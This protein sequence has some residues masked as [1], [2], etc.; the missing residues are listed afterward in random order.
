M[1]LSRHF[2]NCPYEKPTKEYSIQNGQ[3]VCGKC[4]KA[5]KYQSNIKRHLQICKNKV[6]KS[7]YKCPLCPRTERFKCRLEKH[8][9]QHASQASIKNLSK[10]PWKIDHFQNHEIVCKGNNEGNVND[11]QFTPSFVFPDNSV[12]EFPEIALTGSLSAPSSLPLEVENVPND[13]DKLLII[14]K[15]VDVSGCVAS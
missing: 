15:R 5:I 2:K 10:L 14:F 4:S 7:L 8:V 3:Y 12:I 9:K 6:K 13:D 11:E 1:Q